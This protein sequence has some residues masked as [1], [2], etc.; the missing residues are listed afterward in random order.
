MNIAKYKGLGIF[1]PAY[2]IMLENDPHAI[3]SIDRILMENM[4]LLC[5]ETANYL[6]NEYTPTQVFYKKGE[7]PELE[8]CVERIISGCNSEEMR[9]ERIIRFTSGLGENVSNDMETIL[10]GGTEEEIIKRGSDW[11]TDVARTACS[12]I[13]IAGFP[14][15][16]VYLADTEKAYSGHTIIE[17]YRNNVWGAVDPLTNV[18]YRYPEG[19]PIS[20]WELMN[21]PDPIEMHSK[22]DLTPYTRVEQFRSAAISNYF[23]WLWREYSRKY[24]YKTSKINNYYR[25]ILEM[26]EKG[27]P[28]GLRWLHGEDK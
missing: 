14:A 5:Q 28:S 25:S 17:V 20:T 12:L 15:R 1:G 9:I 21:N 24:N 8:Q 18:V 11:C 2:K 7:R 26:A 22:D 13:Q 6:Y 16:M 4:I 23:V 10:I 3:D 27:W 19:K